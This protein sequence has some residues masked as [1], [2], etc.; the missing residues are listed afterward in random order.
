[1]AQSS[2]DQHVAVLAFPFGCHPR[3]LFNL[4]CRLACAAPTVRFS[5]FNTP[6]SSRKLFSTSQAESPQNLQHYYVADG[7]PEGHVLTPGN[8]LEELELFLKAAPESFRKGM[9]MAVAE[10]GRKISC[11]LTDAFLVFACEMARDMHIKWVPFWVPAPYNLSAHIYIDLIHDTY[12]NACG[13]GGGEDGINFGENSILRKPESLKAGIK[14]IDKALDFV[15]GLSIMRFRDLSQEILLGD[16]NSSLFSSTLYRIGGVLPQATAVIMN[17]FQELNPATLT[18]DLKSKFQDLLYVGFLT[19]TL[20]PPPPPP[21]HSD[22]T[23][24]LPWLDNKKPT[25]VAYISFG[26]VAAVPP[27]EFVALAEALEAS[28]VPFLWSLRDNFKEILPTGFL[29]RTRTQGKI[30]PWTPQTHV[31]AH[32]AVGVYVTHCGY[33]SV[34]ESIVGEVPMICRPILGD[35]MMNG[36]MVE[37][38]WGIGV[39][40]EGGVFTKNGMLKS[41]EVVLGQEQ[42]KRMREK[43]RDIKDLV[44]KAAGPN[45]IAS[46]D[47]KSLVEVISK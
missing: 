10:T 14:P 17:S 13:G 9:D 39:G 36:R 22:A 1:M 16:S 6:K 30:V 37:D 4:A 23:G 3:P 43:I 45:G 33:N 11:L 20:P 46:K 7:V 26:T 15:P 5:F 28:H 47:F 18:D 44:V 38:V 32:R 29:Q 21:S 2:P 24:C 12:S 19:L 40:V 27:H 34:F 25:S 35:N 42:G 31:L 8:P 41:L